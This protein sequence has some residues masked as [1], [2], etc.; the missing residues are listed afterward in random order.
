[1]TKE[2]KTQLP[3]DQTM[4]SE[5]SLDLVRS[6]LNLEHNAIFTIS[7]HQSKSREIIIKDVLPAGEIVERRVIVGKTA[8]GAETGV[9]TVYHFLVY[10]VLE[11]LW[12]K[13]G[14]PLYEPVHFTIYGI[15]KR[16]GL[17]SGGKIYALMKRWLEDLRDIPIRFIDSF[18][19]PK[20]GLYRT[21]KP[22]SILSYL[23]I[24]ERRSKNQRTYGYGEFQFDRHILQSLLDNY[25]H[26]VILNVVKSFRKHQELAILLYVYVDRNLAFKNRY[27]VTL[28]KLFEHLD[29]SQKQIRYPA[30]RKSKLAPVLKELKGK[31]LSTGILV[32]A[33]IVKTED[34][35]DYKAVFVKEP[36]PSLWTQN[37][38]PQQPELPLAINSANAEEA[39][40]KLIKRLQKIGLSASQIDEIITN[41]DHEKIRQW[42]DALRFAKA[43][44]KAAFLLA[45]LRDNYE[46]PLAYFDYL[47]Q[48]DDKPCKNCKGSTKSFRA[49]GYCYKCWQELMHSND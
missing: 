46:L 26:P 21:T 20:E 11:E 42:L 34:R 41:F 43:K 44:N 27:E 32:E 12:E 15:I 19:I 10:A 24:R 31:P 7:T 1:M 8:S 6:E 13:A 4:P 22:F 17:S 28:E 38:G 40:K 25:S 47:E 33:E 48:A 14:R 16:L 5:P 29:L 45:A 9:L 18:Y 49:N 3:A 23:E 37:Q 30:D 35:K 2:R 39:D 36:R